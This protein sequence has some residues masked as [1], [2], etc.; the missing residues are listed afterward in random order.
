MSSLPEIE[1]LL[2]TYNGDRFLRQQIDSILTQDYKNIRVLARDDGSND[3]TLEILG[4]YAERL[5]DR[6]RIMPSTAATGSA[7]RNFLLLIQESTAEYVCFSDQDDVWLPYKVSKTKQVMDQLESEWGRNVPLLVFTDLR[8]VDEKLNT[9][10][11]SF[12]A[13]MGIDPERIDRLAELLGK[14]VVTGCTV[15]ANRRLLELSLPMPT[16][17]LMHDRWVALLASVL[18]KAGFLRTQTVLYRQHD[19]NVLGIGRNVIDDPAE[20]RHR[21]L[22]ERIQQFRRNKKEYVEEWKSCHR[23]ARALLEMYAAELPKRKRDLL[24]AYLR[25]ETSKSRIVRI[26][27]LI[28]HRFYFAGRPRNLA[29]L[30][31]LLKINTTS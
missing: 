4:E 8:V 25:C 7:K 10:Y 14:S 24:V 12:W 11:E 29:V 13:H 9:I 1:I 19:R 22:R 2:A 31:H 30:L 23:Q 27:I 26:A 15:M 17:A 18:G 6:F 21:S 3:G 28:S 16:E 5:S 20:K